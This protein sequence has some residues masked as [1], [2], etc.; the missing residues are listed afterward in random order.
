VT[1]HFLVRHALSLGGARS[2]RT[3]KQ[4]S[5]KYIEKYVVSEVVKSSQ[6]EWI[7]VIVG[8]KTIEGIYIKYLKYDQGKKR[9]LTFLIKLTAGAIYPSHSDPGG[10]EV[11]LIEGEVSFGEIELKTGD[12]FITP[13]DNNLIVVSKT[14]CIMVYI[15][16]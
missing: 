4:I 11:F 14:G 16:E 5:Q 7:P 3:L 12:H 1:R 10:G 9:P 2:V 8:D 6:L 15:L 13:P